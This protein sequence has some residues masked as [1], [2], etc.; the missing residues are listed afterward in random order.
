MQWRSR[1]PDEPAY[2]Q[3]PRFNQ[4]IQPVVGV[5]W[6]EA[7]AYCEWLT[8]QLQAEGRAVQARLPTLAEW[9]QAAGDGLY[10]WGP[11]FHPTCANSAESALRQTTPVTM[12]PQGCTPQ[13]VWDMAG[14]VWEWT[15]DK[16]SDGSTPW[17]NLAGGSWFNS[18]ARIGSAARYWSDPGYGDSDDGFRILVVPVSRLD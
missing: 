9:Q 1:W 8:R 15:G 10:P 7:K 12:Y 17:Y 18:A 11:S 4:P 2:W 14:N 6:Y 3:N 16:H 5:S 13:G